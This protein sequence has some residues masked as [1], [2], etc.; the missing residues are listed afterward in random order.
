MNPF[1]VCAFALI[2]VAMI[3]VLRRIESSVSAV[4]S[5][6]AGIV[7][8]VFIINN[9]LPFIEFIN[10]TAK[11]SGAEGY[12]LVMMKALAVSLC[13]RMSAEICRDCG[14][15]ALASRVELAGK[16]SI[17]LLSL[18]LVQNLFDISKD[19]LG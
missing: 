11:A 10:K 3:S 15:S 18:P 14:E 5:A 17:V 1:A 16:V 9:L 19:M 2:A 4:A 6:V 13:C 8:F 7:I 12:F